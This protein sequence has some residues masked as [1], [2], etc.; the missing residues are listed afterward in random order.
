MEDSAFSKHMS[1]LV[2]IPIHITHLCVMERL[3]LIPY[4]INYMAKSTQAPGSLINSQH[5]S[6]GSPKSQQNTTARHAP[7]ASAVVGSKTWGIT[8]AIAA[9]HNPVSSLITTPIPIYL[10]SRAIA[11]SQFSLTIPEGGF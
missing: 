9:T 7:S 1:S 2:C 3:Q 8:I 11:I 5:Q 6:L 10:H 4:R